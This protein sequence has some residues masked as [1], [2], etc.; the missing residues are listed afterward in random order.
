MWRAVTHSAGA[1]TI[2][3]PTSPIWIRDDTIFAPT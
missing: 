1:Y 2:L 3:D